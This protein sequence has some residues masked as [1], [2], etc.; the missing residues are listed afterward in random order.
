MR[1]FPGYLIFCSG[2]SASAA[3]NI[4]TSLDSNSNL[5]SKV[6]AL[7]L[8]LAASLAFYSAGAK[9][10]AAVA[11]SR[12]VRRKF[13]EEFRGL[14]GLAQAFAAAL[15]TGLAI[16]AMLSPLLAKRTPIREKNAAIPAATD[17]KKKP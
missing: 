16:I 1:Q 14:R 2:V 9:A 11:A 3:T 13:R 6:L 8:W 17:V 7:L 15:L 4:A 12:G 10:E 5:T